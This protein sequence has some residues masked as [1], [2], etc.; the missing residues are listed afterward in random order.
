MRSGPGSE[1]RARRY[2]PGVADG[3]R[4][5]A[6]DLERDDVARLSLRPIRIGIGPLQVNS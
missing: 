2:I 4:S 3:P 5:E 1:C 6:V